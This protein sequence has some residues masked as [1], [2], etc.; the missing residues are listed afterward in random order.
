[1]SKIKNATIASV[2]AL[3]I[4]AAM[5]TPAAAAGVATY[6]CGALYGTSVKGTFTRTAPTTPPSKN[7]KVEATISFISPVAIGV[8]GIVGTL[9]GPPAPPYPLTVTNPNVIPAWVPQS[10]VT[11]TGPSP[12]TLGGPPQS[13]TINV[14]GVVVTCNRTAT[15][16]G[17]PT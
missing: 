13:I 9:N 14:A 3:G 6:N 16:A 12:A 17:W 10:K 5:I 8:G 4:T 15:G 2:F 7:L 1:M 11:L